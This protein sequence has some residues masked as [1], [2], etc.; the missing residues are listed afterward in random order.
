MSSRRQ[1]FLRSIGQS[2]PGKRFRS[3][4]QCFCCMQFLA[5]V[6]VLRQPSLRAVFEFGYLVEPFPKF[7]YLRCLYCLL[8]AGT[9]VDGEALIVR[10]SASPQEGGFLALM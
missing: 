1:V 4:G 9:V 10:D 3:K 8:F 7:I 6:L 2:W 5:R